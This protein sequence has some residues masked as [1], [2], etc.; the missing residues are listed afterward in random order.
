M[1][2]DVHPGASVRSKAPFMNS[3]SG[4]P[5][6]ERSS[7]DRPRALAEISPGI[8]KWV[9]GLHAPRVLATSAGGVVAA[10]VDHER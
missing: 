8:E 4:E 2:S 3:S 7:E 10:A 9:L 5:S 1:I 6:K